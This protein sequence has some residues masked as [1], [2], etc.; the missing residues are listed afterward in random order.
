[1]L[2]YF[3]RYQ[4]VERDFQRRGEGYILEHNPH[5]EDW[6]EE[7]KHKIITHDFVQILCFGGW[8]L[9]AFDS[10]QLIGFSALSGDCI[11]LAPICFELKQLHVSYEYRNKGIGKRLFSMACQAARKRNAGKLYIIA[12]S[13]EESQAFYRAMGCV[14]AKEVVPE[15]FEQEPLDVHMEYML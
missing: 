15:L 2:N 10:N 9:G 4:R 14:E 6:S 3:N 5:I 11:G 8:L 7:R 1:M 12:S 13:S